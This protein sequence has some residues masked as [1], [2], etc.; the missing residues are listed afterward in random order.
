MSSPNANPVA[1]EIPTSPRWQQVLRDAI[2]DVGELLDILEL[3]PLA[4]DW[5]QPGAD[6]FPLLVPRSFVARMRKR[7]PDDPLL[8]QVLPAGNERAEHQ[9]FTKDPLLEVPLAHDGVMTKYP[10]RALLVTTSACPVHCRYC[11][12]RHFPYE[13][14]QAS[15]GDWSEALRVLKNRAG[16]R[17][18]ILS[19]GDPLSLSNR[20]LRDLV[21]ELETIE[22]VTTVRIHSR[23]PIVIPERVDS[24]L[25]A[26]LE[27]TR[28][29]TVLVV[30]CNHAN[31]I[32]EAVASAL[33][34][35][36]ATGT[37]LLNQSVLL[38][39]VND[40]ADRLEALSYRLFESG[41][42]P[43]YLHQL[44]RVA[45]AAD[46]ECDSTTALKLIANLRARVPGYLVPKLVQELPGELSKTP[47]VESH[48]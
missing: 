7:D 38:R 34:R 18:V 24:E 46:F 31:E 30:H 33:D 47:L 12:R 21:S 27:Q 20:R 8:R 9:G 13:S 5:L 48:L 26:L 35:V 1:T 14:Q 19:G 25:L 3:D 37:L 32:D 43:Y 45:G 36:R 16:L 29:R 39:G 40:D 23:F 10:S 22:S 28:L 42:L 15:R 6:E 11:F 4:T 44:D 41:V 17:E 2:R